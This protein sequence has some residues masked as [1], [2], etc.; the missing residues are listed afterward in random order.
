MFWC[1]SQIEVQR[2]PA[3]DEGPDKAY[4]NTIVSKVKEDME[5]KP[6]EEMV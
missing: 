5:M 2:N 1:P 6:K 3:E 4:G